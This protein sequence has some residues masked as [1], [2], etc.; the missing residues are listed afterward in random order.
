MTAELTGLTATEMLASYRT[1]SLSPVEVTQACLDR[2]DQTDQVVNAFS[3]VDGDAALAQARESAERWANARPAGLLDGVPVAVKDMFVTKD[4]PTLKGSNAFDA[5]APAEHDAPVV[6]A[7][8]RHGAVLPGKTT[9][10]EF[11][12]KGVTDSAR[13]GVTRN[14]WDPSKTAGGSS[15]GSAAAVSLGQVPLALG[16]DGGGSIRIPGAFCSVTG[17]KPTYGTVPLWPVSPFGTL[18]HA[19]PMSRT[20][21]DTALLLDVMA[22]PDHRDWTA[23][24]PTRGS[25]REN[26]DGGVADVRIAFSVDLGFVDIDPHVAAVVQ[27]AVAAFTELGAHVEAVDPGFTDPREDFETLWHTGAAFATRGMDIDDPG[28]AEICADGRSRSAMDYL[29]ATARRGELGVAMGAF[30]EDW[31]L[32][33]TPTVPITA[34]EAGH[35]VPPG[36]S[37]PRWPSWTPFTYPFNLTQ[38]PAVTV[39]CGF[40]AQGLP[41]GLQIV[42]PRHAD[43]LVLRAAAAYESENPIYR[44]QPAL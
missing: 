39:P 30:H 29:E 19:G 37:D 33:V 18:A 36:S 10:P 8:K 41:I 13:H 16:T 23:L 3:M 38:Q 22:A 43:S 7:L 25:F 35:E 31:D 17:I 26:L 20:V 12:W 15:G 9:T 40:D 11:A 1:R 6:T 21:M 42:G 32:L 14:P 44:Q 34:F 28:L 5:D 2:I 4:W 27:Q 24:A